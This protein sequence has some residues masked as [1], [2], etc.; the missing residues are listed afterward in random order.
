[1]NDQLRLK[2][3]Q[4]H[5]AS[6][7]VLITLN[8]GNILYSKEEKLTKGHKSANSRHSQNSFLNDH[9]NIKVIQL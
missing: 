5:Q 9:L 3:Q 4:I 8:F 7:E 6:K 2:I 1:M